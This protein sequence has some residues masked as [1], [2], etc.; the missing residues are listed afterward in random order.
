MN[1]QN[2]SNQCVHDHQNHK[3]PKANEFRRWIF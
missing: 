2:K 1:P 3:S